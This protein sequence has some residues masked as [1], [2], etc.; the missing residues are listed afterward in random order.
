MYKFHSARDYSSPQSVAGAKNFSF[1][2]IYIYLSIRWFRGLPS[3]NHSCI[4]EKKKV[5]K[6]SHL[7]TVL[8]FLVKLSI[9]ILLV[10]DKGRT[11]MF[12][13]ALSISE[14]WYVYGILWVR[15]VEK[16]QVKLFKR[17]R[18]IWEN[19]LE[20]KLNITFQINVLRLLRL[21]HFVYF[22]Y[23]MEC[24]AKNKIL[25]WAYAII[26][27]LAAWIINKTINKWVTTSVG[28]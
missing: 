19:L 2:V 22:S 5:L 26:F 3:H 16:E 28:G 12:L 20:G 24:Y 11:S 17:L 25:T 4:N 23:R 18:A 1:C 14:I 21:R 7:V 27:K 8:T 15:L 13:G 9:I 10:D 6:S